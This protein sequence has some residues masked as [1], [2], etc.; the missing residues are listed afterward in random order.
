MRFWIY[1]PITILGWLLAYPLVPLAV[2]F[3]DKDGRLPWLFLWLETH[4]APGWVGPATEEATRKTT[5]RFGLRAGLWHYLWRNKAY[6]LRY[7]MR[8]RIT[9]DMPRAVS[10]DSVPK[11]WGFS[12][13]NGQI[14]PYWEYQPRIGLGFVH[15][16][17]RLGWKMK[18]LLDSPG[19]YGLSA[20]I[21]TGISV[22]SD[23]WDD[24]SGNANGV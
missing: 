16:Y 10:G 3:A 7:W 14:G 2:L 6:R 18:P 12:Y 22:R 23:D 20:G 1:L 9:D 13:W 11:R 15:L 4:D 19:P 24:Y 5:A 17:L 21:F 8:A